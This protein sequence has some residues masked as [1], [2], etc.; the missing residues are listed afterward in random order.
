MHGAPLSASVS[1][2]MGHICSESWAE[3]GQWLVWRNLQPLPA[4]GL[5]IVRKAVQPEQCLYGIW[6]QVALHQACL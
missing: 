2:G 6:R 1:A 4:A 3:V 5:G